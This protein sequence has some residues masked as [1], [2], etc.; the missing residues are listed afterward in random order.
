MIRR[1]TKE[2]LCRIAEILVFNNRL[3]FYPIFND[4]EYSFDILRVD[5]VMEEYRNEALLSRVWVYEDV[6]VRGLIQLNGSEVEKLYVDPVF[7]NEG[8]G[9]KLLS[10]AAEQLSADHLWALEKNKGALRFYSR[11]GFSPTGKRQLE[12]GTT[13]YLIELAKK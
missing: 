8:I 3:N 7:Q 1:A 11:F 6:V 13:E 5:K 10:F 9:A 4:I 2:D 12:E